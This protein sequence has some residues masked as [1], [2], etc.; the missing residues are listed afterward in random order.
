MH[1][2]RMA[3]W[4]VG[5]M[6]WLENASPALRA[7]A[8]AGRDELHAAVEAAEFWYEDLLGKRWLKEQARHMLG[9]WDRAWTARLRQAQEVALAAHASFAIEALTFLELDALAA[10]QMFGMRQ[11][12]AVA[13]VKAL[14]GAVRAYAEGLC[15]ALA[16]AGAPRV[17]VSPNPMWADDPFEAL[18]VE[19]QARR[20]GRAV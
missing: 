18:L 6:S 4:L 10:P 11:P 3:L 9:G 1:S 19:V 17:E 13:A 8:A 2:S 5:M 12:R 7:P 15:D 16:A 20:A 14:A